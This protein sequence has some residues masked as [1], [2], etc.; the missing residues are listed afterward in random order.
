MFGF[1][2]IYK[3]V[4]NVEVENKTLVVKELPDGSPVRIPYFI[5]GRTYS[6]INQEIDCHFGKCGYFIFLR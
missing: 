1:K 4:V 5:E 6:K 2:K 3:E